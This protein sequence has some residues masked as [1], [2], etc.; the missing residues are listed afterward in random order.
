[1]VGRWERKGK[2]CGSVSI[3]LMLSVGG[4][5]EKV[6]RK[7]IE[8]LKIYFKIDRRLLLLLG[9]LSCFGCLATACVL[10]FN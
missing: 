10:G 1:M 4:G 7:V 6:E 2:G 3:I 5:E 9:F 8:K